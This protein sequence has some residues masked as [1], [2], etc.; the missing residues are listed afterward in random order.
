MKIIYLTTAVREE[1]F[2]AFL[3]RLHP[4]PNPSNQ[5]FHYR[6]IQAL[7]SGKDQVEVLSMVPFSSGK[8]HELLPDKDNFHYLNYPD[9]PLTAFP[10]R[11]THLKRMGLSLSKD[12]ATYI[13]FDAL[14]ARLAIA[15]TRLAKKLDA[16][17]VAILTDNPNNFVKHERMHNRLIFSLASKAD[18]CLALSQGLVKVYGFSKKPH[19]VFEGVVDKPTTQKGRFLKGSYLY[20]S[21]A[22]QEQYGSKALIEAYIKT[23]P[24][25]DLVIAGHHED[26]AYF[27]LLLRQ[28]SRI[29]FLGQISRQ[30]NAALEGNA[31]LVINPRPFHE[32]WDK[33]C[34]PSKMLE[35]LA[36]GAPILSTRHT[37][38]MS[39]FPNDVNWLKETDEKA[40]EA[41]FRSHLDENRKL[42]D[43]LP[44]HAQA[45]VLARYGYKALG[46]QIHDFLASL[47]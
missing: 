22:L 1:D 10:S 9:N 7:G 41:F 25:Y 24:S 45:K 42:A 39:L 17:L 40:I 33:E 43:L 32:A 28:H 26:E 47:N 36:S 37:T 31:A 44:N 14:N 19:F 27:T 30:D 13:L 23:Q 8:D 46:G 34:V 38:L 6:L 12:P 35:Y 2:N 15:A 5:N 29:H 21:G 4:A 18:A 3:P 11:A 16:T 20:F